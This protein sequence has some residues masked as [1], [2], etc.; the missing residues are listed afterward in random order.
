MG[1]PR[2]SPKIV[3]SDSVTF[4][5]SK[6]GC[7]NKRSSWLDSL[8]L[9]HLIV[10]SIGGNGIFRNGNFIFWVGEGKQFYF[11]VGKGKTRVGGSVNHG[12]KNLSPNG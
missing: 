10:T 11:F 2:K 5:F 4:V 7:D 6:Q 3:D 12:I 9:F 1:I 8:L